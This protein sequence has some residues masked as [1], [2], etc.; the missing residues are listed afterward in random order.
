MS[1]KLRSS[2]LK[3]TASLALVSITLGVSGCGTSKMTTG[4]ISRSASSQSLDSMN[5]QQLAASRESIGRAYEKDPKNRD[6]AIAYANVLR[7][8]GQNEQALAVMRQTA[9]YH[10]NDRAVLAAYGKALA[11]VG[12]FDGALDAIQRA[13]RPEFP[14]WKLL[15]AEGA[16][17]DQLGRPEEAR[18]RYRKA[19]DLQPNEASI[20]SNLGMS[21]L[22]QGD[23]KTAETYLGAAARSPGA[24]STVRQN[25][26]LVIGLQGR[27]DEAEQVARR[28]LSPEQAEA[29]VAYLR[30]MLAQQDSLSKLK[31]E[32]GGQASNG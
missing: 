28:E 32:D 2:F 1:P 23:L 8:T 10:A 12:Q 18:D 9:I 14:D 25:L 19:S 16:I 20:Q 11:A 3:T 13:Q 30:R 29:N 27:F 15:S 31:Q 24:D 21:Y 4:S 22:L 6:A 26:A 5:G 17:L 7:M